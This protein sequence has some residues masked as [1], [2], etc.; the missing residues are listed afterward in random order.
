[1]LSALCGTRYFSHFLISKYF[2]GAGVKDIPFK[3]YYVYV[4]QCKYRI[5]KAY[6]TVSDPL[7]ITSYSIFVREDGRLFTHDKRFQHS[8]YQK[9]FT[10]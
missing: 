2:T 9:L 1:M 8:N 10:Y 7:N 4:L 5:W 6:V 3:L